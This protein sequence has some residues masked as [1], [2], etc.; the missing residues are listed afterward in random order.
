MSRPATPATDAGANAPAIGTPLAEVETPQLVIDL[1][2]LAHNI[3]VIAN[4]YRGQHIRLRPH[5]KN[6]KSPQILAMQ[7]A[8]GGTVGGVCAAKV[9]EAEVFANA[10][11]GN[12]LLVNQ[13]VDAAKIKRLAAI[14]KRVDTIVA[15]DHPAQVPRLAAGATASDATLGVVIE[16]DTM[17]RRGGVRQIA[18][19]VALAKQVAATPGLRFRGVMSHQ[20]PTVRPPTR[21]QRFAEGGRYIEHVLAAK[22]AIENAGLAVD[23]VS[24]GE[25][26][27]YD[28][29]ATY[30]EVTEIEGGS[31]V[32]MEVPYAY[33]A[34]FRFAARVLG[35]IVQRLDDRRALG[36][37]PIDAI[38]APNG[39]PTVDGTAGLLV[40]RIDHHGVVLA[41]DGPMPLAVGDRFFLLTH[42]QDITMNRWERY[43]GV[44]DGFVETII[45]APARGCVH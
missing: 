9:S 5:G 35:R 42:Q 17:M 29:A 38:G 23:V 19:A 26:W 40:E 39:P 36:D 11:A 2:A 33:M 31:Y 7:I 8:A 45:D 10:G 13:V 22:A 28:V 20:V 24:T 41:S 16:I 34:E 25:T 1:D 3:A 14:A 21:A 30:P 12:V 44:R 37:V 6:H 4:H 43:L 32:V 27:T 18:D 15:V